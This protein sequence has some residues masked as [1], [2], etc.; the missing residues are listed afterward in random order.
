MY[1]FARVFEKDE[2]IYRHILKKAIIFFG[3]CNEHYKAYK[4]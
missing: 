2:D 3:S 1:K 4:K